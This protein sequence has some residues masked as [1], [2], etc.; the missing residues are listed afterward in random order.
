MPRA[1]PPRGRGAR[2]AAGR[3]LRGAPAHE[4]GAAWLA[5]ADAALDVAAADAAPAPPRAKRGRGGGGGGAASAAA[6]VDAADAAVFERLRA[7]RLAAA[8]GLP[9]YMVCSDATLR[10]IARRKPRDPTEL[11]DIPGIGRHK[12]AAFG[13]ALLAAIA[14]P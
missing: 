4:A 14:P 11:L 2:A 5:D 8:D 6:A 10:E 3:R 13:D 7:A 1:R 9:P 12:A